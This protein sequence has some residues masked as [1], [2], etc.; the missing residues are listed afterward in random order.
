MGGGGA[1]EQNKSQIIMEEEVSRQGWRRDSPS[2][3]L[4]QGEGRADASRTNTKGRRGRR[5]YLKNPAGQPE[6]KD[7]AVTAGP[8]DYYVMGSR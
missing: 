3:Q 6:A 2:V 1:K 7:V 8:G 4:H 5:H